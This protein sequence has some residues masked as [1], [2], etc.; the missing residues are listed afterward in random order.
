MR[1]FNAEWWSEDD[2]DIACKS[3]GALVK[4]INTKT[5]GLQYQQ[6]QSL[7]LYGNN[8][9]A[10]YTLTSHITRAFNNERN[11][12]KRKRV[13]WNVIKA[14][15]DSLN[16]KIGK[17]KVRPSFLTN[18]SWVEQQERAK[19]LD[20]FLYG[21][22]CEA[23]VYDKQHL[24][25]K[26]FAL[27]GMGFWYVYREKCPKKKKSKIKVEVV[28]PSE[29]IVDPYDGIY[30]EPRSMYRTKYVSKSALKAM[31][32]SDLQIAKLPEVSNYGAA[33][34]NTT[35]TYQVIAGWHLPSQG[36]K[37][38]HLIT[39]EGICIHDEEWTR[40]RFPFATPRYCQEPLGYWGT[41]LGEELAGDQVEINR[42]VSFIQES[43]M[44]V[45][46]PRILLHTGSNVSKQHISN[47]VGGIVPWA[48][49]IPPQI[50]T[51][52]A[53][54]GDVFNHLETLWRKAFEKIGLNEL[55]ISG[56]NELGANASGV[57]FRE[58]NQI[59]SERFAET[60]NIWEKSF[61][62]LAYI[63]RDEIEEIV[64]EEGDYVVSHSSM[65]KGTFDLKYSDIKLP[66]DS[67]AIQV[68]QRSALPKTPGARLEYVNELTA[69]GYLGIEESKE[70]LDFPDL[71]S[72]SMLSQYHNIKKM[73]EKMITQNAPKTK[74]DT[75]I[76][77]TPEPYMNLELAL[78][79]GQDYYV[80]LMQELPEKTDKEIEDKN[81]RLD[82]LRQFIDAC[83]KML[84]PPPQPEMPKPGMDQSIPGAEGMGMGEMSMPGAEGMGMGEM[85]MP[86]M[87]QEQL[88]SNI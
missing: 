80:M 47:K 25:F 69:K 59:Q 76:Y 35:A 21:L 13:H 42:L 43:M 63:M 53:V 57:A 49:A 17:E 6:M 23:G 88:T 71:K 58:Y 79:M 15:V 56:R 20:D 68:F 8:D 66:H 39:C 2:K 72:H 50:V 51:P 41:G 7:R 30:G 22:F 4:E 34:L 12:F 26:N 45:S 44:L 54:S 37:G 27:F 36:E 1:V 67:Y 5:Q 18:G 60:Q 24:C 14:A 87:P 84:A 82:L 9:R 29:I 40:K 31:G 75:W 38:R 64:A 83:A 28:Y 52:Q 65:D 77:Y 85:P 46:N 70:L 19:R 61:I 62:D 55:A 48:G 3:M 78:K 16:S 81:A 86:E 33:A 32:V 10:D 74:K 11:R 73:I